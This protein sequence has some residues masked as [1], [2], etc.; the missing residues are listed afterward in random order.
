MKV[1]VKNLLVAALLLALSIIFYRSFGGVVLF[2]GYLC[3]MEIPILLCGLL[4][5]PV[6]GAIA[7]AAAPILCS[8]LFNSPTMNPDAFAIAVEYIVFGVACGVFFKVMCQN[9]YLS[10]ILSMYLGKT[11]YGIMMR[12]LV[13]YSSASILY[14][15]IYCCIPGIVIEIV[16]LPL[17][18]IL[19]DRTGL[20]RRR[21]R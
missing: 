21:E 7:G 19:L 16:L 6:L 3:A 10:L 8:L 17:I 15:V 20:M 12:L 9:V 4:C 5:G 2:G 11:A 14:D 13:N 1:S 18:A